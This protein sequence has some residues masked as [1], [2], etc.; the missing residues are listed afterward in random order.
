MFQIVQK[1]QKGHK[2]L[3]KVL[4]SCKNILDDA[5]V[6]EHKQKEMEELLN[7][8]INSKEIT[9]SYNNNDLDD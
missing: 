8:G 1:Y 9:I 4:N 6:E 5:E 2:R 7:F 3:R